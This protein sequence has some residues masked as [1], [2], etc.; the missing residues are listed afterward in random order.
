MITSK[1]GNVTGGT[2]V[3]GR[4][5]TVI[6]FSLFFSWFLAFPFEGRIL[7]EITD[8]YG[9]EAQT[10]LL[11]AMAAHFTGLIVC[12]FFVRNIHAAKR[13]IL[14]S[15]AFCAAGTG[16]FFS[17]PGVLWTV[18]LFVSAF[19]VGCCVAAW[20]HYFKGCTPRD[21]LMKTMAD[22]LIFTNIL[23]I[24]LNL[25]AIYLSPQIG[26]GFSVL[27]LAA[28]FPAALRLPGSVT[29]EARADAPSA[30]REAVSGVKLGALAFLCL[31]IVIITIT[32]GLM[33]QV[34]NHSYDHL[35][36][37]TSW[38]WAAPY[39]AALF[40]M[41]S[42]PRKM[43]RSLML[44][45]AIAMIGFSFIAFLLLG[46][47]WG[48]YL[49]VNTL[50]LGACGVY[51]LF[52]WSV[53]GEM[54]YLF[55][56]PAR[57]IGIG[58]S[59]NVLGVLLGKLI[60]NAVPNGQSNGP[61]LLALGVVCASLVM[62]PILHGLLSRLLKNHVYLTALLEIPGREQAERIDGLHIT[63]RLTENERKVM[64]LLIRGKTY[65]TI[66]EELFISVNTVGTHVR[67]IYSKTGVRNKAELIYLIFNK[68]NQFHQN[69]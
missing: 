37:L 5:M 61:A 58:L 6:V 33:Y 43:N 28:A 55:R 65:K 64:L 7:Y 4:R 2:A 13:L 51:D 19:L 15:I 56:N 21:E 53:L 12:G 24:M 68:E 52:W 30:D 60:G 50:M 1:S 69:N 48:D 14:L 18:A 54:M 34:V 26:L 59:A 17:P 67:N 40:A 39:I 10:L 31:F 35:E 32:S 42:L 25:S 63:D 49:T 62:L 41:R 3:K 11:G 66:A 20:G 22:C 38:Y 9:I 46:R 47:S 27:V 16:V 45:A 36:W 57:I 23:M 44:Y 29:V 8:F